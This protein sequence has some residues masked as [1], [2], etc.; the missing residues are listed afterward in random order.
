MDVTKY[1]QA[2]LFREETFLVEEK[3]TA[4]HVGSGV[5]RVLGTPWLIAFMEI[6][7]R[8]LLDEH[9]PQG[10]STVGVL[11]NVRH[12]APSA[13][14]SSVHVRVEVQDVD[15]N[16][17]TLAMEAQDGEEL[18]GKGLHERYVIDVQRFLKRVEGKGK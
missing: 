3:H 15:G 4:P 8:K 11:V 6:T 18:V 16:K 1:L 5:L 10:Y 14:G 9:L 7:S 17:V 13:I 12:L 2:A